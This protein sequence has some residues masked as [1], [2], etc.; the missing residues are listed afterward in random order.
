M[1][2][3][4][5][6][7]ITSSS[8]IPRIRDCH[9]ALYSS[10][11]GPIPRRS[12]KTRAWYLYC[13]YTIIPIE[14]F[15]WRCCSQTSSAELDVTSEVNFVLRYDVAFTNIRVLTLRKATWLSGS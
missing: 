11:C 1:L 4:S 3:G 2:Y 13:S 9:I 8:G 7:H 14:D 10:A 6:V 15:Y 5:E 12:V